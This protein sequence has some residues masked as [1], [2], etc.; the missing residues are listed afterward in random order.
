[1][2]PKQYYTPVLKEY[3]FLLNFFSS[4]NNIGPKNSNDLREFLALQTN[5]ND[6][7]PIIL[8]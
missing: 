4:Q 1:M 8:N 7:H 6:F 2:H 5:L 3:F